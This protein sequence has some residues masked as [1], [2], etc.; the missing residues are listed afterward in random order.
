MNNSISNLIISF[1]AAAHILMVPPATAKK[2]TIHQ[3]GAGA[4]WLWLTPLSIFPT[5]SGGIA[6]QVIAHT[7]EIAN[8]ATVVVQIL[9]RSKVSIGNDF[10]RRTFFWK[11]RKC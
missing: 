10:R 2:L 8:I 4:L 5:R 1:I 9:R 11:G 6:N 3:G 7:A